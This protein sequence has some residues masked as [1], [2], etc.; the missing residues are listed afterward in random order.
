MS[1][2]PIV[3]DTNILISLSAVSSAKKCRSRLTARVAMIDFRASGTAF[4]EARKHL[5]RSCAPVATTLPGRRVRRNKGAAGGDWMTIGEVEQRLSALTCFT[6]SD[7]QRIA[8]E[9]GLR[10]ASVGQRKI[11]FV[12]LQRAV[13]LYGVSE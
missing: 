13:F 6:P 10:K 9:S 3:P 5:P 2:R 12:S 11:Q 1:A 8:D 7:S 4:E